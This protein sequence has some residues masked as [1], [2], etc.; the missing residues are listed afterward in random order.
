MADEPSSPIEDAGPALTR[1]CQQCGKTIR[2]KAKYSG[3]AVR[4]PL[5]G[6][7]LRP[8]AGENVQ[9]VEYAQRSDRFASVTGWTSSVALHVVVLILFTGV[10]WLSGSS[11]GGGE[12]EVGIVADDDL[13]S[14]ESGDADLLWI[15]TPPSGL[16]ALQISE[17]VEIEPIT[18]LS[19][20]RAASEKEVIIG[21]ELATGESSAAMEVD[22][23]IFADSVA[24]EDAGKASFFGI[25]AEGAKFVYVVDRSSSMIGGKL[26]AVKSE[27]IRRVGALESSMRFFII[28][29]NDQPFPMQASGL[30]SATVANKRQ[31]LGWVER[32][33]EDGWTDPRE[34]MK[35]A[36]SLKP[37]AVW[38]LSDGVFDPLSDEEVCGAIRAANPGGR[39]QIH[40]IAFYDDAGGPVLRR[41]AGENG[42]VYRFVPPADSGSGR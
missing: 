9:A 40:T 35:L 6:A 36:L 28:F 39:V 7:A 38:L 15:Q 24:G 12:A 3:L 18:N 41:I 19:F 4:C 14:I 42:G 23:S 11:A 22:W 8:A 5:C 26:E 29:Y 1:V 30:V 25:E 20:N 37:D 33:S 10:T 34:A 31:H 16:H 2:L 32:M 21:I 13:P 27:L 17:A